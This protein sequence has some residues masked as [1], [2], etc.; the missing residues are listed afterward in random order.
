[1]GFVDFK[2][3]ENKYII[4]YSI[5]YVNYM[6]KRKK[7][8][9]EEPIEKQ[10]ETIEE[11]VETVEETAVEPVVEQIEKPIKTVETKVEIEVKEDVELVD[12]TGDFTPI[13]NPVPTYRFKHGELVFING[14]TSRAY[15]VV[16]PCEGGFYVLRSGDEEVYTP[17]SMMMKIQ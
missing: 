8:K 1:M 15:S 17:E 9:V 14:D 16:K 2:K 6:A 12:K 13:E 10:V 11:I 4:F 3:E 5:I 7:T